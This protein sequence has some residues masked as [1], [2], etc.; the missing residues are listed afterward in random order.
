MC[1]LLEFHLLGIINGWWQLQEEKNIAVQDE[2]YDEAKRLKVPSLKFANLY[3]F[4][5]NS[6]LC[7]I[8]SQG[9]ACTFSKGDVRSWVK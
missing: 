3:K 9:L 5:L 1:T 6:A 2:D 7:A 8:P 4:R